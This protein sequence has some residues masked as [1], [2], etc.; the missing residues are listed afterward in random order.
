MVTLR[1]AYPNNNTII[2]SGSIVQ[3]LDVLEADQAILLEISAIENGDIGGVFGISSQTFSLPGTDTNNKFF[4]NLFDL[5][6]TPNVAFQKSIDCQVLND[7][8]EVFTG[9]LYITNV[10]TDQKGYTTYQV[11]VVNES[12]DLKFQLEN[13]LL[14][15]VDLSHLNHAYTYANISAS[16]NDNLFG[17]DVVY[18]LVN[19]GIPDGDT[20]LPNYALGAS[21]STSRTFDNKEYPLRIQQFRPAI[22]AKAIVDAIFDDLQYKYT[23]SFM[24]SD[25]FNNLYVLPTDNEG[26]GVTTDTT[27]SGSFWVFAGSIQNFPANTPYKVNYNLTQYDNYFRYDLINDEYTAYANGYYDFSVQFSYSVFNYNQGN[28][29]RFIVRLVDSV[30]SQTIRSRTFIDPPYTSTIYCPFPNVYLTTNK[31]VHIELEYIT[32]GTTEVVYL[33]GGIGTPGSNLCFFKGIGPAAAVGGGNV[34]AALQFPVESSALDFMLGLVQKFNLIIEPSLRDKKVLTIEPYQDW[35]NAGDEVDW[36]DKVDRTERFQIVHPASEQPKYITFRD[37]DDEAANNK[38]T[39]LNFGDVFG[40]YEYKQL[41]SDLSEGEKEIGH[42]FAATPVKNIPGGDE[43]IIPTLG[44]RDET[45]QIRPFKFKPRLLYKNGLKT[46]GSAQGFDAGGVGC[47]LWSVSN[48]DA[49]TGFTGSYVDC[50]NVSQSV[51]VDPLQTEDVCAIGGSDV[52]R[53]GGT[54][55]YVASMVAICPTS[56]SNGTYPGTF[57]MQDEFGVTHRETEWVQMTPFEY[58][59]TDFSGSISG[60]RDLHF[61][62]LDNPGW[63]QYFQPVQNGRTTLDAYHTYWATYINSLYDVDAR[64]LTCNVLLEPY[65][66][67]NIQLNNKYFIDGHYYR[68]N[69]INGANLSYPDSI[70]V[71]LIKQFPLELKYPRRR[72]QPVGSEPVDISVGGIDASG[73]VTYINTTTGNIV[74]DYA[75]VGSAANAD[76]FTVFADTNNSASVSWQGPAVIEG[77]ANSTVFGANNV[78]ANTN[79]V[80]MAGSNNTIGNQTQNVLV[81]GENNN[82]EAGSNNSVALGRSHSATNT[83]K[84]VQFLGGTNNYVGGFTSDSTIVG[85]FELGISASSLAVMVGGGSNDIINSPA[86][87]NVTVGGLNNISDNNL[88]T[89][90]INNNGSTFT[91]GSGHTVIGDV[92]NRD[93]DTHRNRS[94]LMGSIYMEGAYFYDIIDFT[95][96]DGNSLDLQSPT[97][98]NTYAMFGS[99]SGASGTYNIYLPAISGS[100]NDKQMEGRAIRFK[101]DGSVLSSS[102][103]VRLNPALSDTGVTIDGSTTFDMRGPYDAISLVAHNNNWFILQAKG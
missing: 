101:V 10:I 50:N 72:I 94:T 19:Y 46:M 69:K 93:L 6:A 13:F 9:K 102:Y 55:A 35:I 91:S 3:D 24:D 80:M 86:S 85:G 15:D 77:P 100:A 4:G 87:R 34:N 25:Y 11:N 51:F 43:V 20:I 1:A 42:F 54:T 5:G 31:K 89:T 2:T 59:P 33:D 62:N 92:A 26:L 56:S 71:E 58:L 65:E 103:R 17:G 21:D 47:Y 28:A 73:R 44:R 75:Y 78:D 83:S 79:N 74:S 64:K 7:G 38:Y 12:V 14:R 90:I 63:Y 61:G 70:E 68:I 18:P 37:E 22:R 66:I 52:N 57:W 84:N 39:V 53:T 48:E 45:G 32:T 98:L 99:W 27:D 95:A 23:S 76:G 29:P 41:D 82:I 40:T 36:T 8:G 30:T 67:Q 96:S 49:F 16:W 81:L 97:Y 88:D 60:S